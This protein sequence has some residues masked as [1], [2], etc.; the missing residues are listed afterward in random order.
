MPVMMVGCSKTYKVSINK[1]EGEGYVYK[2]HPTVEGQSQE[3]K[4]GEHEYGEGAVVELLITPASHYQVK[5][6]EVNGVEV[7]FSVAAADKTQGTVRKTITTS[8]KENYTIN[9]SFEK[10]TYN[11]SFYYWDETAN[12]GEGE[13]VVLTDGT[14][15]PYVIS[16]KY[17]RTKT[18]TGLEDFGFLWYK[19]LTNGMIDTNLSAYPGSDSVTLTRDT[20]L[21]APKTKT[22]NDLKT[23]LGL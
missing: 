21:Y 17:G 11:L 1:V 3:L 7:E 8:I 14:E 23:L 5:K 15:N 13:Y 9:I 19:R 12:E 22:L 18:I 2:S 10:R 4:F 20:A 16:L 6:I